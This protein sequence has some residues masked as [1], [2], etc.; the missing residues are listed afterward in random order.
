MAADEGRNQAILTEAIIGNIMAAKPAV[1][2]V[3]K[4]AAPILATEA[5]PDAAFTITA[6]QPTRPPRA[7]KYGDTFVVLDSRGDIG[8]ASN[9]SAGLFHNDTRHLS[10]LELLVNQSTPLLLGSTLRDDNSAFIVDLTNPDLMDGQRIL[11]EKDRVHILRT[12]FLWRDTAYQRLGVRNYGDQPVELRLTILFENDFADLFEVRGAHRERRGTASAKLHGND[13]VLLVYEGLD[14]KTRRTALNF[15]P[16]PD[17]LTTGAAVYDLH[18]A[19]G[20]DAADLSLGQLRPHR[21][22]AAAVPARADRGAPRDARADARTHFGRDLERSLQRNPVPFGRRSR[23]ADDGYAAGPLPLCRH[24]L[25]LDD[26]RPRR[27]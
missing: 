18:L 5:P 11:L 19:A 25:V 6:T 12:I 7:L 2:I 20:R 23:D 21:R 4:T 26:I 15:D 14:R 13:R 17:R 22:A 10:R 16:P 3:D 1:K 27:A 24:P 9:D 8:M